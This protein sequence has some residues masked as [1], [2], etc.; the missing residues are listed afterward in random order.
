MKLISSINICKKIFLLFLFSYIISCGNYRSVSF[1]DNDPIYGA[2]DKISNLQKVKT[3]SVYKNYFNLKSKE[4]IIP[5]KKDE[6][7][8]SY[9]DSIADN[10]FDYQNQ[11]SVKDPLG[12]NV[13][14]TEVFIINNNPSGYIPYNYSVPFNYNFRYNSFPYSYYNDFGYYNY[15]F[16]NFYDPFYF[17]FHNPYIINP[18]G[19]SGYGFASNYYGY[20]NHYMNPYFSNRNEN[21]YSGNRVRVSDNR[22]SKNYRSLNKKN[23]LNNL[24]T[25]ED[26]KSQT[27]NN[28]N[29]NNK[30]I[31][32]R[33]NVGRTYIIPKIPS[34]QNEYNSIRANR[35]QSSAKNIESNP[36]KKNQIPYYSK[37]N[38]TNYYSKRYPSSNKY[39][40]SN[41]NYSSRSS[42]SN[43]ANSS[44]SSGSS[45]SSSS[46]RRN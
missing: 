33:I 37:S 30:S 16:N 21:Y 12:T 45:R 44:R 11:Y 27:S 3:N 10:T 9:N 7:D 19:Y 20:N 46:G 22:G 28:L 29:K 24:N 40:N 14:K 1:Y 8:S 17:N 13:K 34:F 32:K 38:S 31:T 6:F 42:N 26:S 2:S 35:A 25:R 36:R 5:D 4:Y 43:S 39:S 18:Y 41:N 15:R 23:E